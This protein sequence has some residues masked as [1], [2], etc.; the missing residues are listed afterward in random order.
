M[1]SGEDNVERKFLP[2]DTNS[3][4][5]QELRSVLGMLSLEDSIITWG[6]RNVRHWVLKDNQLVSKNIIFDGTNRRW[7][8]SNVESF[9]DKIHLVISTFQAGYSKIIVWNVANSTMCHKVCVSNPY[10][11]VLI[12]ISSS[13]L[14]LHRSKECDVIH[15]KKSK[16]EYIT[17][18]V[19]DFKNFHIMKVLKDCKDHIVTLN[20]NENVISI[21][22]VTK[23][24]CRRVSSYRS[25][26]LEECRSIECISKSVLLLTCL[27]SKLF[28]KLS[29]NNH[30][31]SENL[32]PQFYY[33]QILTNFSNSV[34]LFIRN[35]DNIET[36]LLI[37]VD[38]NTS[39]SVISAP[40]GTEHNKCQCVYIK[41]THT[42]L[43]LTYDS[44]TLYK[45]TL[46]DR[47]I[48]NIKYAEI[49]KNSRLLSQAIRTHSS[50]FQYL[51]IEICIKIISI[52]SDHIGGATARR[53][54][55]KFFC[56]PSV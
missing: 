51:P 25:K 37:N 8:V 35:I 46:P 27:D 21:W 42:I 10:D 9:D 13:L 5:A 32:V 40:Y 23:K 52:T 48:I 45:Y 33:S 31:Y 50:P 3:N 12:P 20:R 16:R 4:D 2:I 18:D 24:C 38:N 53:L 41:S 56:K 29:S 15:L 1:D 26:H 55:E 36:Y 39:E 17:Y 34:I 19:S 54:A 47:M 14:I 22:K 28:L 44:F 43:V 30:I 49:R 11:D 7:T 6:M